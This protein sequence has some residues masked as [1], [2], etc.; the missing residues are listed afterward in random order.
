MVDP[1]ER[2]EM[3]EN[4]V[5]FLGKLK[6]NPSKSTDEASIKQG[7]VLPVLR[8]LKWNPDN[9]DEVR[10]EYTV[11]DRRVDYSLRI[12]NTDKVF[13]E[14]KNADED[15]SNEKIQRQLLDYSFMKGIKISILT[16]GVTWWFYLSLKPVEWKARKFY[17][18]DIGEQEISAIAE[19]FVDLLS[20]HNIQ[21]DRALDNAN[22]ID[23]KKQKK[24]VL[25][26]KLPEA[27]NKILVESD[28]LLID[29]ISKSAE[30]LCGITPEIEDVKRL[31]KRV[32]KIAVLPSQSTE[33][34][35]E[36]MK[37]QRD[38]YSDQ[39]EPFERY[40]K[41]EPGYIKSYR[42]QLNNPN[43]LISKIKQ[44]V[45]EKG[46][47]S[48]NELKK[49]CVERFGCISDTSGSIGANIKVLLRDGYITEDGR[50]D[51][52]RFFSKKK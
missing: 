49:V 28:P 27:W 2:N 32:E 41:K 1:S 12:N 17:S 47:V 8:M 15:L 5:G 43:N 25:E 9:T 36:E 29:L 35:N 39:R 37:S 3:I 44:F 46:S 21:D 11:E 45:D 52:R 40:S 13:I 50:A 10:P 30:K 18:I 31:L 38:I 23:I 26:E 6:T 14:A 33:Q 48:F 42:K 16:N 34:I 24:K 19:K 22:E 51:N 4:L 7:I 20:K